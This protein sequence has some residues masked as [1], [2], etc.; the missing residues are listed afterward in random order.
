MIYAMT[1]DELQEYIETQKQLEVFY[2]KLVRLYH[3]GKFSQSHI[4]SL[5]KIFPQYQFK[6]IYKKTSELTDNKGNFHPSVLTHIKL[7]VIDNTQEFVSIEQSMQSIAMGIDG[8]QK[9]I[10]GLLEAVKFRLYQA[11]NRMA[12]VG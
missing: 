6:L 10:Y 2:E 9:L 8:T 11:N 4:A 5:S 12:N 7:V 3:G 1:K